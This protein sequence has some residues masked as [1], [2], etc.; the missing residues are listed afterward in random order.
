[1][2]L[3]GRM[4]AK[5]VCHCY[6]VWFRGHQGD[7][8]APKYLLLWPVMV[9]QISSYFL[10]V[11]NIFLSLSISVICYNGQGMDW[12][13]FGRRKG[14]LK[15]QGTRTALFPSAFM[16]RDEGNRQAEGHWQGLCK[17]G[18]ILPSGLDHRVFATLLFAHSWYPGSP[19]LPFLQQE[20]QTHWFVKQA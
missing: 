13:P 16:A 1:M 18:R 9:P 4:W 7:F 19:K 14:A 15:W 20:S 11:W 8:Y 2:Y 3:P 5:R 6:L 12:E 10:W 17:T